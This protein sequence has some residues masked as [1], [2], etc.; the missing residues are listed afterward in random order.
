MGHCSER[1]GVGRG[2]TGVAPLKKVQF[3]FQ[4]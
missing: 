4:N 1:D 2:F 3:Y